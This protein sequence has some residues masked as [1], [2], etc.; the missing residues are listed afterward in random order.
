MVGKVSDRSFIYWFFGQSCGLAVIFQE[1]CWTDSFPPWRN[2]LFALQCSW[3]QLLPY[4]SSDEYGWYPICYPPLSPYCETVIILLL[5]FSLL[6]FFLPREKQENGELL[7]GW[8]K[9]LHNFLFSLEVFLPFPSFPFF[10]LTFLLTFS[11][12]VSYIKGG[13]TPPFS[14]ALLFLK[15][16]MMTDW[17][18]FFP[19]SFIYLSTPVSFTLVSFKF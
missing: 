16:R 17:V 10:T 19:S 1:F 11:S 5:S 2:V 15:I 18:F 7:F 12:P 6:F 3:I 13:L 8:K 9:K 14:S 4:I